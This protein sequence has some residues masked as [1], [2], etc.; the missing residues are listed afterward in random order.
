M[1]RGR[2]DQE[3]FVLNLLDYKKNGYYVEL[4]AFHSINGSNTY[5]LETDYHWKGVSFEINE[6]WHEE[7]TDNRKNPCILGDATK[8]NYINYFEQNNFP[9]QID[10][11]QID[12]DSGY[13]M[14]GNSIGNSF[15][16]LH[17]LISIPLSEYR[18]SIITFEHDAQIEYN[19]KGMREAQREILSSF[20][21]KLVVREMHEDY[22]VDPYVIPYTKFKNYFRMNAV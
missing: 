19:N 21:Y 4:G 1:Y 7:F 6:D 2:S 14:Q 15:L 17:G 10:Y 18:F 5:Y 16:S 20:G 13:D 9:K 22:W 12:I 11:L 8:F 3:M